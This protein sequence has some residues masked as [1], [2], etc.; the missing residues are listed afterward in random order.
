MASWWLPSRLGHGRRVR[1][2]RPLDRHEVRGYAV[3][4]IPEWGDARSLADV[5]SSRRSS[6]M[7]TRGM[8]GGGALLLAALLLGC[9]GLPAASPPASVVSAPGSP[10]A[11]NALPSGPSTAGGTAQSPSPSNA[12]GAS[13]I[14]SGE[15]ASSSTA[16]ASGAPP[17]TERPINVVIELDQAR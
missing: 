15:P 2:G 6:L 10:Q 12:A 11:V 16:Q 5:R 14:G 8:R 7:R 13:L 3:P 17:A 4:R 1:P 9:G